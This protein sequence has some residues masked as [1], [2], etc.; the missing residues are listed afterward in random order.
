MP[1]ATA[2]VQVTSAQIAA[3]AAGRLF[4]QPSLDEEKE[5]AAHQE[6]DGN[7]QQLFRQFKSVLLHRVA[8]GAG[9]EEGGDDFHEVIAHRRVAPIE[10]ELMEA[11]VEERNDGQHG[12]GLD[13]DVEEVASGAAA[14]AGR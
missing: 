14:I 8:A 2:T 10:D 12:A 3:R 1:Q 5:H 9:D 11:P 13:D 7:G 4:G 6:G